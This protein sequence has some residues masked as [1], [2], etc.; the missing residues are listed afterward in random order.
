MVRAKRMAMFLSVK[1]FSDFRTIFSRIS[2]SF[3]ANK[4]YF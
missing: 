3:V 1:Y 2:C 4:V